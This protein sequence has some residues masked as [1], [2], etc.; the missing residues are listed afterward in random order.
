MNSDVFP[1]AQQGMGFLGGLA[2]RL[3]AD[4]GLGVV[5]PLLLYEDGTVQHA[6]MAYERVHGLPDWSFPVHPGKARPPGMVGLQEALAITGACMMLRRADWQALAG[7]D[8]GYVIGDFEDS[9][10]CLRLRERGL[11]CAVDAG[12]TLYHLERQSQEG[13][14]A[15]RFNTTLF[16]AWRHNRRWG[17]S[18]LMEAGQG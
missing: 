12:W 4:A 15:W 17:G 13:E 5:G 11:R 8:E 14:A 10:L 1:L 7:F 3:E 6:G 16:N 9:D 18:D 2:E